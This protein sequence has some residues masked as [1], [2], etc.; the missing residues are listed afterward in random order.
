MKKNKHL[1]KFRLIL[2][3]LV[4]IAIAYFF[5]QRIIFHNIVEIQDFIQS[6]GAFGP[7]IFIIIMMMA[8]VIS[9]IPSMPLTFS[10]G[11]IW[12][13]YLG[14]IYS[15]I[16]GEIGAILSF[17]LARKLG[18]TFIEKHLHQNISLKKELSDNRL[19]WIILTARI[20]PFFQFDIVSYGAGLTKISL[21]KF[22]IATLI[23]M[24]PTTF[25]FVR[26]GDFMV[27]P[28]W[29]GISLT[30]LLITAIFVIPVMLKKHFIGVNP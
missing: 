11:I 10:S 26:F 1:L 16:G 22:A 4:L 3:L 20:F 8:V 12:G 27:V 19:F 13:S 2:I 21:P 29:I 18:R 6:F 9:P 24:L 23:G 25:L 30:I 28:S 7:L 15:V 14:T 5:S 17:I